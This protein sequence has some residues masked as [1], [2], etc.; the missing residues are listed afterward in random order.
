M[1][2]DIIWGFPRVSLKTSYQFGTWLESRT[3]VGDVGIAGDIAWKIELTD[4][5]L[6]S[7]SSRVQMRLIYNFW[8][9][10]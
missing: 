4:K 9:F 6:A 10:I 2:N 8:G 7:L 5:G 3:A 1:M